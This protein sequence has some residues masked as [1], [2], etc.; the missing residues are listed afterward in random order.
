MNN[1]FKEIAEAEEA[2]ERVKNNQDQIL[3]MYEPN[4]VEMN[5]LLKE[6][7]SLQLQY[8]KLRQ[9]FIDLSKEVR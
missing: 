8:E 9:D 6:L 1:I 7:V 3:D 2:I 5:K 4:N